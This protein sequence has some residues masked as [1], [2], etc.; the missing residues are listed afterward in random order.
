MDI[1][2]PITA[3]LATFLGTRRSL[4]LGFV[5]MIAVGYFNGIIRANFLGIFTTFM[6]DAG[7]LGLYLGFFL[8][9]LGRADGLWTGTASKFCLFLVG[10][11]A[12]MSFIP[13]NDLFVQLVA[14]RATVWFLPVMILASRLT[15]LDLAVISRGL[16]ILNLTALAGG[17]YIY[18][19]GVESLYPV[20]A[21]TQIIYISKDVVDHEFHRIPST[22]LSSHSYGGAMLFSL[23]FLLERLFGVNA[24]KWDRLLC[25]LGAIAAVAGI[26]LCAARQPGVTLA[27]ATIIAWVCT[28]FHPKFGLAAAA[29][30]LAALAISFGDER[31]Q[32]L[33]TLEDTEVVSRRIEG[34]AN[35]SFL[36]LI[37]DYPLGV[38]MGSSVGTSIP[39]FLSDR[40]PEQIGMENEYARILVDQGWVGLAAWLAFLG[41]LL[42][43]PPPLRLGTRW[44]IGVVL[45]YALVL[46]NWGT[47]FI[48]TGTL[49]AI[50]SSVLLLTQM[51]VLIRARGSG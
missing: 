9:P 26:L 51:G 28:R 25:G 10:W 5:A 1:A 48:G 36:E 43:R 35:E 40:A 49:A 21:V 11:P 4:G 32:R 30:I 46:T 47:A 12:M 17:I 38:G 31:L 27:V 29:M 19:N 8:G 34:S 14:L 3:L 44:G 33:S 42:C 6:F 15:A 22:F 41:W 39:F 7:L 50:P 20:N 37:A 18:Q 16:A 2:F 45:M 24:G 23:P 13:I